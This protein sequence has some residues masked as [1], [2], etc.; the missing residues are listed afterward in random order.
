MSAL[1]ASGRIVDFILLLTVAEALV[2]LWYRRRAGRGPAAADFIS[3][4]IAG[5]ALLV[6]VR[7]ALTGSWWG[8]MALSLL[9]ALAAHLDDLRRRWR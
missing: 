7:L 2:L 5:A 8:W 6:T 9:A 3:S 4:L 1:F